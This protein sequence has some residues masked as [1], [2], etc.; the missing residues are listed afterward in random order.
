[1]Q[2]EIKKVLQA[3]GLSQADFARELVE[4]GIFKT[5]NSAKTCLQYHINGKYKSI[6]DGI[7]RYMCMRF[8]LKLDDFITFSF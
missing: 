3:H 5:F 7:A 1:M 2:I 6:D 4:A 8:G